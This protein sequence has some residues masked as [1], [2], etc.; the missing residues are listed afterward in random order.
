MPAAAGKAFGAYLVSQGIL[1]SE[2][3]QQVLETQLSM[4]GRFDTVLLDMGLLSES[5]LLEALG[6][7]HS[8]RTASG[9]DLAST[10]P[11]VARMISPRAWSP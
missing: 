11:A 1:R 8:T 5:A 7:F 9:T 10:L 6:Q 3:V 2:I 4:G